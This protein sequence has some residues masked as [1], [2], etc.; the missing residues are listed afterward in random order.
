MV[1]ARRSRVAGERRQK[2]GPTFATTAIHA[3]TAAD[4]AIE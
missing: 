4:F 1:K 3:E 2:A